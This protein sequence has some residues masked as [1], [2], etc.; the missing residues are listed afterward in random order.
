M[1]T[2]TGGSIISGR[3]S[4]SWEQTL[5]VMVIDT[6]PGLDDSHALAMALTPSD[7]RPAVQIS[8][9]CTVA[10]NVPLDTVTENARWL[11]GAYG[12]PAIGVPVHRGAAGPL[13]GPCARAADIHGSDGLGELDRWEVPEVPERELPAALALVEAARRHPGQVTV[14]ALGP[15]T[16]VALAFRLEPRLPDL[17]ERTVVMG[18]AIHGRGNLTCNAEFN[19][20]ADPAAADLVFSSFPRLSL[21][22]W[23]T[24]LAHSFTRAELTGFFAGEGR[25]AATLRKITENRF[26]TD[27]RYAARASFFRADPLAM[28]VALDPSIVTSAEHHRVQVGY[29]PGSLEHGLTVVD[30]QDNLTGRPALEIVLEVDQKRLLELL[31]V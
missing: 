31:T 6:D 8:A 21:V 2:T 20:G 4:Y 15:L 5:S 28:A 1:S 26:A 25:I 10:G 16:N 30:W 14:V 12:G 27:P 23:E 17:L 7:V 13:A 9:V 29:G 11:L 22:S 18:G 19:I 24:T 3:V